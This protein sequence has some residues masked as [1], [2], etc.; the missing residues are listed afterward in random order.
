M[1]PNLMASIRRGEISNLMVLFGGQKS[2]PKHL[3][4]GVYTK[5]LTFHANRYYN[6]K[7]FAFGLYFPSLLIS[8]QI[9]R[10]IKYT[11]LI[12]AGW[13]YDTFGAFVPFPS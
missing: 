3:V 8:L 2:K 4:P 1:L 9:V 13:K 11:G 5:K 10:Y 7:D 12:S 6:G